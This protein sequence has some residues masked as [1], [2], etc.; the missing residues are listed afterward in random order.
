MTHPNVH[1]PV[2]H[3]NEEKDE[4]ASATQNVVTTPSDSDD[5]VVDKSK[6]ETGAKPVEIPGLEAKEIKRAKRRANKKF[7][8]QKKKQEKENRPKVSKNIQS[9][10][11]LL[12][13]RK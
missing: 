4:T 6:E 10:S 13:F 3:N 2:K 7:N 12:V 5:H 8:K 11:S 9:G 1:T